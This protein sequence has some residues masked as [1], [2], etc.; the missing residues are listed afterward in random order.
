MN[1]QEINLRY[2]KNGK[3]RTT[4]N[5]DIIALQALAL[6]NK[7]LQTSQVE[8]VAELVLAEIERKY[9]GDKNDPVQQPD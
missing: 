4:I 6:V 5:E 3:Y 2:D 8:M 7:S 9:T 1:V